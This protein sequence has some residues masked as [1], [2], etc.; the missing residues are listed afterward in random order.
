MSRRPIAISTAVLT[1][2]L[3]SASL[4]ACGGVAPASLADDG[5]VPMDDA[6]PVLC[7]RD[8]DCDDATFCTGT[9]TCAP[10]NPSA[11]A[12]GCVAGAS[13][14][15]ASGTCDERIGACVSCPLADRD[16]DG[17][18]SISMACGG[19]D[20]D[21]ADPERF[22]G[23]TEVC[24]ASGHDEDCDPTSF[25]FRDADSDGFADATCCNDDAAMRHCGE[26]CD[27]AARS[28]HPGSVEACDGIDEDCDVA[29]DEGVQLRL[30]PDCDS[31]R[32]GDRDADPVQA[33]ALPS[34]A[35]ATCARRSGAGWSF[36]ATDCNDSDPRMSG[37]QIEV[38]F[39]GIDNN[40]NG[41]P[42]ELYE[43]AGSITSLGG[44]DRS[45][46]GGP[47]VV[48]GARLESGGLVCSG[49]G[50]CVRGGMEP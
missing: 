49:V 31:D 5:G 18:G 25:G 16:R 47:L 29:I 12:H 41:R 35:P 34:T 32:D 15:D 4:A 22:P 24:D 28:V 2:L 39:D 27:D 50:L 45:G 10:G 11:D 42:D 1:T 17:D 30:F 46:P 44:V 8:A 9:E 20:C 13:P 37:A 6:A 38:P 48:L 19:Q 23:N 43:V 26:D 7:A 33:C 14:C 36:Y 21:D 3:A 40:C